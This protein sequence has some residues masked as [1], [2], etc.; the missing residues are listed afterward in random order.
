[1]RTFFDTSVIV[2]ASSI[3]HEHHGPSLLAYQRA[4][5]NDACC[6]VHSLAEV[7]SALTRLPG[8]QRISG[9]QALLVVD[10]IREHL[11]TIILDENEYRAAI[12]EA[13]A[14]GILGGTIYDALIAYCALRAKASII[15]T[16]NVDHFRRCG[17]EVAKRVRTP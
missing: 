11:T 5:R 13:S 3:H 2:A 9:E 10:E 4:N 1:V 12:A 16:W 14:Q 17:P 7:Y 6:A 15:Y 8:R